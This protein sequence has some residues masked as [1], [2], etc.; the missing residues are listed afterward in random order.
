MILKWENE[1]LLIRLL[2]LFKYSGMATC[3][4]TKCFTRRKMSFAYK[5]W[6]K[7]T[8]SKEA[9]SQ[10][11]RLKV[12]RKSHIDKNKEKEGVLCEAGAF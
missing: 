11:K 6:R 12:I 2:K 3:Y 4:F 1:R 8:I 9:K 7:K 10:G 5:E